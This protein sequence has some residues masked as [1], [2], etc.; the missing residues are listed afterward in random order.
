MGVPDGAAETDPDGAAETEAPFPFP[1][2]AAP[3]CALGALGALD[4]LDTALEALGTLEAALGTL[5]FFF[6]ILSWYC[7]A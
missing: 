3:F 4:D 7:S 5:F 6:K 1:E 2:E